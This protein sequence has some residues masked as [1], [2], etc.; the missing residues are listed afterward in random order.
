VKILD[1][2]LL[3]LFVS[4]FTT[5]FVILLFIFIL[6]TVWLFI[7]ELAGKDLDFVSV[8]KFLSF[9]MPRVV[10]LV[11]PLSVLLAS[12]M[13]FGSL[14]ENYEFAAMKSSGIS[15]QRSMKFL[16]VFILFLSI[17][18]FIFA[19]NVIP[20]AEYKFINFRRNIAQVKPAMAIGEGQ[21]SE[22]GNYT[23]KV[24]KKSGEEGRYLD[25]VTIHKK[26]NM[27]IGNTTIIKANKGELVSSE[28][29]N[30]LKLVLKEGNYYEDI[31][32]KKFEER[33]KI[34][35]AKSEF[36]KYVINIDLSKLNN[37]KLDEEQITN[38]NTMLTVGELRYTLDS[39]SQN[40]KKDL[41][42]Y[43]DN[44]NSRIGISFA[45]VEPHK[46]KDTLNEGLNL[47][48][49]ELLSNFTSSQKQ[50]IIRV[51][52]SNL[53]ANI[54]SIEGSK[55]EFEN[56]SKNINLH[57]IA[58]YDKFVVAFSCILMF[59][60]GAPLGAIIR[61]GGLG[62]PIVFAI[63]IFIVFHFV[64]TFGKKLAQENGIT[65]FL[66]CW[67][68]T[69]ILLPLAIFLTK[70]ATDDKGVSI[71]FDWLTDFIAKIASFFPS[72]KENIIAIENLEF[73]DEEN[74]S[75]T[76]IEKV[77]NRTVSFSKNN[78]SELITL[79]KK[80]ALFSTLA[81]V[82]DILLITIVAFWG[83]PESTTAYLYTFVPALLL[84]IFI[85]LSYFTLN[86]ISLLTTKKQN[87]N[88][89]I[90]ILTGFPFYILFY[91]YNQNFL[92][93]TLTT[94]EDNNN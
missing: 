1:K 62:L 69:L 14:A 25:K 16:T 35:F 41:T 82:F 36:D 38:T 68:S 93:T 64:N 57:W 71:Q 55:Y 75:V 52:S 24:E 8:I 17:V 86:K 83:K 23:I 85:T 6:Q 84:F 70:R 47:K 88:L 73:F 90:L 63:M 5:V 2:Y 44:I 40:Y 91:L 39:L 60:I 21:F 26:S 20:Y 15:L 61:K 4:T 51:T 46:I 50:Q 42:S 78:T 31:I 80:Y 49:K 7:G 48:N 33:K 58:L 43:V 28:N 27:G 76:K 30:V 32:P 11:L 92:K 89:L 87:I 18:A 37:V 66:G 9:A 74:N 45:K 3:K 13:T 94:T 54:F 77:E 53:E 67:L 19:N 10:P 79:K 34:P 81:L 12:I 59:F 56:K 29:S 22:I 72:K 65:P